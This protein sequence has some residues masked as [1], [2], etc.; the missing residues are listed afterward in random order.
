MNQTHR[1]L[2]NESFLK[3]FHLEMQVFTVGGHKSMFDI[4]EKLGPSTKF[5]SL[6]FNPCDH[7]FETSYCETTFFSLPDVDRE[8]QCSK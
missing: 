3:T 1:C 5:I 2:T 6:R 7:G 4:H 8:L